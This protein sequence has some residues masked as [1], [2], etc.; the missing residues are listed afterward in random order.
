MWLSLSVG[1]GLNCHQMEL[2]TQL[3]VQ[4][5]MIAFMGMNLVISALTAVLICGV[6]N[7]EI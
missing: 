2:E 6:M 3:N 4:S 7:D 5:A 1:N